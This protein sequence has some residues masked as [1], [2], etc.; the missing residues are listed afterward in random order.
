MLLGDAEIAEMV[1]EMGTPR[2]Q[3]AYDRCFGVMRSD[4]V[5]YF[6][7]H[8]FGGVW[9]DTDCECLVPVDQWRV[10]GGCAVGHEI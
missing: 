8:R 7:L 4:F 5:R 10:E 9:F 3:E 2:Q 1:R 6:A